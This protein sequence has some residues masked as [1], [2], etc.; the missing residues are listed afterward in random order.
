MDE[1]LDHRIC[2]L[3]ATNRINA[4]S[5]SKAN[6][7]LVDSKRKRASFTE[8]FKDGALTSMQGIDPHF[9]QPM[10]HSIERNNIADGGHAS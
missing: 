10:I 3:K 7:S 9:G 4:R 2:V 5:Q 8:F 6:V 1:G